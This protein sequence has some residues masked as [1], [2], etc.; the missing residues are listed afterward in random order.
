MDTSDNMFS[1]TDK[2]AL[3]T[4]ATSG[5]GNR[6]SIA[7]S[8]AGATVIAVGRSKERLDELMAELPGP[9]VAVQCDLASADL[10]TVFKSTIES[11]VNKVLDDKY[12]VWLQQNIL[13]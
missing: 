2:V 8:Q 10:T 11:K 9:G 4:G 12:L 1:L 5:I 7:L 6:Q 13:L 3:V